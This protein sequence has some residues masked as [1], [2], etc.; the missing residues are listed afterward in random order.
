MH[1]QDRIKYFEIELCQI[2]N[3]DSIVVLVFFSLFFRIYSEQ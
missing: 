3:V 1:D 2:E